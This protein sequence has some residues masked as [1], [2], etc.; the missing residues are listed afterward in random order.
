MA[1][2]KAIH[3]PASAKN[4][5]DLT[6]LTFTKTFRGFGSYNGHIKNFDKE[7]QAYLCH[8]VY[9]SNPSGSEAENFELYEYYTHKRLLSMGCV[10]VL[11]EQHW[12]DGTSVFCQWNGD[13]KWWPAVIE[14]MKTNGKYVVRYDEDNTIDYDVNPNRITSRFDDKNWKLS[15]PFGK[16]QVWRLLHK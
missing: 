13:R 4:T 7:K 8:L 14:K 10:R 11:K 3:I 15:H 2:E 9:A 1:E 6:G 16:K 12:A 5:A